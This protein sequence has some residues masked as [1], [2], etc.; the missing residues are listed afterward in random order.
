MGPKPSKHIPSVLLPCCL[1]ALISTRSKS[2]MW[3]LFCVVEYTDGTPCTL[4]AEM[5]CLI[6]LMKPHCIPGCAKPSNWQPCCLV[7]LIRTG[8]G[9][10]IHIWSDGL[11]LVWLSTLSIRYVALYSAGE[12][13]LLPPCCLSKADYTGRQP[14]AQSVS[15]RKTGFALNRHHG[16]SMEAVCYLFPGTEGI[17]E[18]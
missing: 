2:V 10:L 14:G 17:V 16:T 8:S 1:V 11:C 6:Q 7:A 3:V 18:F 15:Q 9:V 5:G 13:S 12:M 4:L